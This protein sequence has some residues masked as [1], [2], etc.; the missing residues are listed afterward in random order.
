LTPARNA[1]PASSPTPV[2][3]APAGVEQKDGEQGANSGPGNSADDEAKKDKKD[4]KG[5]RDR[6]RG[7][8]DDDD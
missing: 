7:N 2:L 1:T 3:V 4:K 6:G 5:K 8:D